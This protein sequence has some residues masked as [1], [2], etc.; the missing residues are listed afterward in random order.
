MEPNTPNTEEVTLEDFPH[1]FTKQK[2]EDAI[3]ILLLDGYT[4]IEACIDVCTTHNI[5]LEDLGKFLSKAHRAELLNDAT[6]LNLIQ[7]ARQ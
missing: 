6:R 2:C 4:M 7:K 3:N 1:L 5:D